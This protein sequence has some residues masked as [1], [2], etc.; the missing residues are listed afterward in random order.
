MRRYLLGLAATAAALTAGC[1][2]D[3]TGDLAGTPTRIEASL[4]EGT[5][6]IGDSILITARLRDAQNLSLT[7]YPD[8]ASQAPTV[9]STS[10]VTSAPV[11]ELRFYIKG[12]AFGSGTVQLSYGSVDPVDIAIQTLPADVRITGAT[13]TLLS[14]NTVQLG[15]DP[16]DK[17]GNAIAAD[18]TY[19]WSSDEE[20]VI[21]VDATGLV[22]ARAPGSATVSVEAPGGGSDEAFMVVVPGTFGGTLSA[23]TAAPGTLVT[24]TKA[25]AG[26]TFDDDSQVE[27]AENLGWV[28]AFTAN[29]LTFAVPATGA[30]TAAELLLTAMG[31]NQIAQTTTFTPSAAA[32]VHQPDNITDDCSDPASPP[33]LNTDKSPGGWIYFS[34]RGATQGEMGCQN[35]G[36]GF[37]HYFL[38]T[39]GGTDETV[40]IRAEWTLEGDND[41]IVCATDYSDCPAFGFSGN[42]NDEVISA[43]VLAANTTYFIIYSPWTASGGNNNIRIT[44]Q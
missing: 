17:Q 16:L 13:D 9:L 30:T 29:T 33:S 1:V 44:V 35:G 3:P 31:P 6:A 10:P 24:V 7:T 22:A 23:A 11:P 18:T 19:V 37:D 28:D 38:Y 32:D 25:A 39:T 8:V 5:V 27:L 34:H 21:G 2:S 15:F 43:A 36:S 41:L 12:V 14:G 40:E 42:T 26:P 4:S 20:S